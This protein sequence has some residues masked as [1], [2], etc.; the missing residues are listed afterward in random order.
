VDA[1]SETLNT[2]RGSRL[3]RLAWLPIPILLAAV[4]AAR[5]TGLQEIYQFETLRL[6]FDFTFYTLVSVGTLI[7]VG[8]SFLSTGAP[9]L[10]LLVCG[11]ILWS[12]AGT[13]GDLVAPTRSSMDQNINVTIF[14]I[15][16]LLSG[17][18]HLSGSLL[19]RRAQR[20]LP[21]RTLWLVSGCGLSLGALGLVTWAAVRHWLPVFFI[22]GP[23]GTPVRYCVLILAIAAFA[24]SSALLDGRRGDRTPFTAWYAPAMSLLA[25]GLFGIMIQPSLWSAINWLARTAQWLGGFYLLAAAVAAVR[26]KGEW[27]INLDARAW[28]ERTT[29]WE[30][31]LLWLLTPRRIWSL[32]LVWRL[33]IAVVISIAATALRWTLVSWIGTGA[34]YNIAIVAIVTT[35]ILAGFWPGLVTV[36]LNHLGVELFVVGASPE[37][38]AEQRAARIAISVCIGLFVCIVFHG[39]RAAQLRWR[40]RE[41]RFRAAF[42]DGAVGMSMLSID[43]RLTH[44]NAAFCRMLGYNE[45]ELV[46]RSIAD[47]THPED[48][49]PN[50]SGLQQVA[51]GQSDQYG[52]EKRYLRKDGTIA[53]GLMST[54]AVRDEQG[55]PAYLVTHIQDITERKVAE[56]ALQQSEKKY[57]NLFT[58]MTEEVHFWQIVRDDKGNIKTW[59]LVDANPP[60]LKTW[61]RNSIE[62]ISGRTPDEIFGPGATEHY[63]PVVSKIMSEGMPHSFEDYF[64]NLDRWFRFTSVP[65]GEYFITTGADITGIKKS[66]EALCRF[67]AELEQQVANRTREL[68]ESRDNL[69]VRV[70]ERTAELARSNKELE[71]F[72]YIASHDLQEPLRQ[73]MSFGNL[74]GERY[75]DAFDDKGRQFMSFMIEG[76]QRMSALVKALLDYSRVVP[77][78]TPR[79]PVA[80]DQLLDTAIGNLRLA[81]DESQ[82]SFVRGQL[83][84]VQV[85]AVQ[86]GQLFQNLIANAIKF[87][88]EGVKPEIQIGCRPDGQTCTFWVK[89]NG[90]GIPADLHERVFEIFQRLHGHG[91]YPGTGIGLAICKKIVEHHGGRIWI[92]STVGEGSTFFFTLPL[93]KEAQA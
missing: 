65:L 24:I 71:Q 47:I 72:A 1:V 69:E 70:A 12:L 75:A 76:S 43:M 88:R 58:N 5:A 55:R 85:D 50:I 66:Q 62:E 81:I 10:L 7:L 80:A 63:M 27:N 34:P 51:C 87:R 49:A 93:A 32:P 83:A 31:R 41:K 9:G 82:A 11:V 20:S 84:T 15:V 48:L 79:Q 73:I 26:Q 86:S 91:K 30:D 36:A 28:T 4:I 67:N 64:P 56:E 89:D 46:G 61:G 68:M 6:V 90:I 39:L 54:A 40:D 52:M 37:I 57:R 14:N 60:T 25:V 19:S 35:S 33:A 77:G 92:E 42:D 21:S 44:V 45:Q 16:I 59:R 2:T 22:P 13:V 78:D 23:G 53:W 18:C 74:L 8:R 3:V 29:A 17:L 38:P